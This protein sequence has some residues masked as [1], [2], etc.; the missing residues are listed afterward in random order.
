[1]K[2]KNKNEKRQQID[3]RDN[4]FGRGGYRIEKDK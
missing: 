1:M 3:A 2:K 4:Q